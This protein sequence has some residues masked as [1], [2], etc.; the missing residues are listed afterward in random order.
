MA[1][2]AKATSVGPR[3]ATSKGNGAS[4]RNRLGSDPFVHRIE[5]RK[6]SSAVAK[7]EDA[8]MRQTRAH[9]AQHCLGNVSRPTSIA[10][11]IMRASD[12]DDEERSIPNANGILNRTRAL[13]TTTR[14]KDD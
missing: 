3:M 5:G 10:S 13:A 1:R 7:H 4:S 12:E 2:S 8:V 6:E 14:C 9:H 11:S